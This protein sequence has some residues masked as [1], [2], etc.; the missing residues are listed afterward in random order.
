MREKD[1]GGGN[2][3]KRE[4]ERER[5]RGEREGRLRLSCPPFSLQMCQ[6]PIAFFNRTPTTSSPSPSS[7]CCFCSEAAL[8]ALTFTLLGDG[9]ARD[10]GER[11]GKELGG[12]ER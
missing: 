7:S 4:R 10:K 9:S 12:R 8:S 3:E 5:A 6:A 1:K 11:K 2:G